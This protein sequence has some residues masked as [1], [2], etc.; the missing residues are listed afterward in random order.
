MAASG[1]GGINRTSAPAS[2]ARTEAS[3]TEKPCAMPPIS[4]ASV[5]M[6]PLKPISSRRMPVRI[7]G[8]SVAGRFGASSAGTAMWADMIE[9]TPL[10]IAARKGAHSICSRRGLSP[11]MLARFMCVSVAVSPCPGKCLAVTRTFEP[12]AECAPSMNAETN[13]ETS[14]GS[15]P[16]DLMLMMGLSGLLLTSASGKKIHCTPMARASF[17]VISP[18]TLASFGSREAANAIA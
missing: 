3:P 13:F 12:G 5:T 17:A 4:S 15:S 1:S 11:E 2:S 9:S 7:F 8:E 10:A 16:Y 18:S 14:A 6:I